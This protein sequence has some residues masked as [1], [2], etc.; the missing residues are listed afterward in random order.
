MSC[1]RSRTSSSSPA[2]A[3]VSST[4]LRP[5]C[6]A[7]TSWSATPARS[8]AP[9]STE[10]A[11]TAT[12]VIVTDSNR[13]RAHHW[14]G[15]QDVVGLTEDDD[16]STPDV[17][18]T[19][20][21]D[22]RLP[23]FGDDGAPPTVAVQEGPVRARATAYGEP[24]AY[25]PE[26]RPV[27]A[28]DGDPA[29]AWIVADRSDP[30][31]EAI[32]LDVAEPIDHL[33]LV[34]PAGAAAVRH[35][36]AITVAVDDEPPLSVTLD[37]RSL[38][39]AGQRV[40]LAPTSGPSTVTMTI[41]SV[42]VPD[43]TIGPALAGVGL[44][45]IDTG[46]GPTTEVVRPPADAVDVIAAAGDAPVSFVFTRLRTEPTDRWRSDPEPSLVR[47]FELPRARLL[48]PEIT[49][50]LDRRASDEVL[51]GLLGITG[52]L[53]SPRLTGAA[54]AAGWAA[55]DGDDTTAWVTPLSGAVGATLDLRSGTGVDSFTI[56]QPAGDYSPITGLRL[57][58]GG[59]T[60]EVLVP[61]P[62][63]TARARWP[64]HDPCLPAMSS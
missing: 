64:C 31:G 40:E 3:T 15:S 12:H 14:R 39:A 55:A 22:E 62:T 38:S 35:L 5:A 63:P 11:S 46:L 10:A 13:G 42:V 21:A 23:V 8:T 49:V 27:M 16:P 7:V 36:G 26:Q 9:R 6:S 51:A 30:V 17:L 29:T 37:E 25:R 1:G 19:D 4:P 33:T 60:I 32:R 58:A 45:E 18:R 61:P 59:D 53:A 44:A 34:Q 2:A 57:R 48:A 28:V 54:T 41:D 24:F 52:P 43:A 56:A 50:R 20:P 47:Q